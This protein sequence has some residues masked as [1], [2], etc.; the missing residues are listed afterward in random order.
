MKQTT[1]GYPFPNIPGNWSEE[2]KRFAQGLRYLFDRIFG[3]MATKKYVDAA[4]GEMI[5]VG[6]V[7]WSTT[8]EC[9]MTI[10]KWT[11]VETGV[12]GMY[13]WQRTE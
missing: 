9:P 8:E 10:G 7:V 1:T 6:I 2:G 3:Q 12:T 4:K 13:G 11:A 5:P